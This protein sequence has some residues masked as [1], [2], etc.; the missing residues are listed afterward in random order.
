MINGRHLVEEELQNRAEEK[1]IE[2]EGNMHQ[3]QYTV[4]VVVVLEGSDMIFISQCQPDSPGIGP[5][6]R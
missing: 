2:L 1:R 4:L 5:G 6:P 3:S